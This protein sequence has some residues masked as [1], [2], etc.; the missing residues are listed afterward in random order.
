MYFILIY[1]LFINET[2][3]WA[4][5]HIFRDSSWSWKWEKRQQLWENTDY[6]WRQTGIR[7]SE[8][9]SRSTRFSLPTAWLSDWRVSTVFW[10]WCCEKFVDMVERYQLYRRRTIWQHFGV[11]AQGLGAEKSSLLQLCRGEMPEKWWVN[12]QCVR[13][14]IS[15]VCKSVCKESIISHSR[16]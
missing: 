2:I 6:I 10:L 12:V 1:Q 11:F 3:L 16:T 13:C 14:L 7:M 8:L 15:F 9:R 4:F 5:L